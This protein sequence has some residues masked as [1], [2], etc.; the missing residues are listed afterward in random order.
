MKALILALCLVI[1]STLYAPVSN[2]APKDKSVP[3]ITP[4][5]ETAL[6]TNSLKRLINTI[7][8]NNPAVTDL[9]KIT[10][11]NIQVVQKEPIKFGKTELWMAKIRFD[12][13]PTVKSDDNKTFE[14]IMT[15]DPSG[16]YQYAD[17][18]NIETSASV[19]TRA[20]HELNKMAVSDKI[21]TTIFKGKG[22][23][24]ILFISD[25]FCPFC[26]KEYEF[27]KA[28]QAKVAEVKLLHMPM[29]QLH[30]SAPIA[31]ALLALAKEKLPHDQYVKVVDYA[32]TTLDETIAPSSINNTPVAATLQQEMDL[33]KKVVAQFPELSKGQDFESFFYFVKGKYVAA[34]NDESNIAIN[35]FK[36]RGTPNTFVDGYLVRGFN[37]TE[38]EQLIA[39]E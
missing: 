14:M 24:K 5:D 25:P 36:L 15:V 32:Y 29:P 30:P 17:V 22:T 11:D 31:C 3:S 4:L 13:M 33:T 1:S 6:R 20:K 16:V 7:K 8:Q 35:Q 26:R 19:F 27:L 21:G 38:L 18:T 28:N 23:A 37:K 39:T 10:L 9:D 2:A 12:G 34:V